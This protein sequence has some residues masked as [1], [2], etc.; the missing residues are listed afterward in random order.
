VTHSF[1]LVSIGTGDVLL[2]VYNDTVLRG[3][4]GLW[5]SPRFITPRPDLPQEV[6]AGKDT[7]QYKVEDDQI[8][9]NYALHWIGIHWRDMPRLLSLHLI[10]MW[11]PYTSLENGLPFREFPTRFSSQV[12]WY[13]TLLMPIPIFLLAYLGLF[14]TWRYRKKQLLI[15]YIVIA[16]TIVENLAFWGDMR[17]RA[18]IEPLLVL[19][20]GG[21]LWWFTDDEPAKLRNRRKAMD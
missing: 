18:P 5:T 6:L 8:A 3:T 14:V 1:V 17:F 16:L 13:M 7:E 20:A 21:V 15:V 12:V 19:L 11:A 10:N 4:T 9:T 2:G